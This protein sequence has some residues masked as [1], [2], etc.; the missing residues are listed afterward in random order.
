MPNNLEKVIKTIYRGWKASRRFSGQ[1][2]PNAENLACFIDDKL[3]GKERDTVVRH[4]VSC[5]ICTEYV[6]T[7]L[8]INPH[9][10]LDVPVPLLEKIKKLVI[11]EDAKENLFEIFL[12]LKN[13]AFEII[14]TSA[15]VLLG[16]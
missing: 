5:D 2:H 15:D 4:L 6:S 10:S 11:I 8:K 13:E 1:E 9:L 16:Q 3:S 7:Q 12:R 14:Q